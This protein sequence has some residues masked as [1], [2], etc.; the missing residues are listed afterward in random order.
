[1]RNNTQLYRTKITGDIVE[2]LGEKKPVPLN[3][4]SLGYVLGGGFEFELNARHSLF[5]EIRH[6]TFIGSHGDEKISEFNCI[7]GINL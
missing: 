2:I 5:L 3:Q 4:I 7:T 1:M 6:N